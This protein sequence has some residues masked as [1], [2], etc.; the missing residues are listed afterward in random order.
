MAIRRKLQF[1]FSVSIHD[2][3]YRRQEGFLDGVDV[4]EN[5]DSSGLTRKISNKSIGEERRA[6]LGRSASS[7][8]YGTQ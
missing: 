3:S 2:G 4:D 1:P 6:L 5:L 7:K 8:G